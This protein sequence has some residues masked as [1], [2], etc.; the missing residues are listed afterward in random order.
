MTPS[1]RQT[2]DAD[3][4]LVAQERRP[5]VRAWIRFWYNDA[6][7]ILLMLGVPLLPL[8]ALLAWLGIDGEARRGVVTMAYVL[9]IAWLLVDN[10]YSNLRRIG[11]DEYRKPLPEAQ[12][13]ERIEPSF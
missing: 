13:K 4:C 12:P 6:T 3:G 8:V 2:L 7:R 9:L 1:S 10:D 11:L 5:L